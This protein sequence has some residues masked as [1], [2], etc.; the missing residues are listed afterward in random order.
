MLKPKFDVF[1]IVFGCVQG[2]GKTWRS[3]SGIHVSRLLLCQVVDVM[4]LIRI[5]DVN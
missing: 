1:G 4:M 3:V 5:S 2:P